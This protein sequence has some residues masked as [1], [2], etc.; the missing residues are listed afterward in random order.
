MNFDRTIS[1]LIFLYNGWNLIAEVYAR[2]GEI[3]SYLC[4][5][6]ESFWAM[7]GPGGISGLLWIMH[8]EDH[9]VTHHEIFAVY[10]GNGNVMSL[11]SALDGFYGRPIRIQPFPRAFVHIGSL[12]ADTPFRSS[13]KPV[14]PETGLVYLR[15]LRG[16][17]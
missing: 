15:L 16:G 7:Q 11:V 17:G 3:D 1:G 8:H 14:D 13:T 4:L 10:D 9:G 12:A 5:G 2:T 6:S